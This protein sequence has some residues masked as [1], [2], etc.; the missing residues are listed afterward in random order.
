MLFN[1]STVTPIKRVFPFDSGGF[2]EQLYAD[3]FHRDMHLEDFGLE[4]DPNTPGRVVSLFFRTP[5]SYL[6]AKPTDSIS[7]DPAE[8]EARS[9][10]ALINQ[11]LSNNM[12]NRVSGVEIQF[13]EPLPI[14]DGL[15]AIIL[16][17]TLYSSPSIAAKL[18]ALK[19]EALPY[20]QID[21]QRPSEYVTKLF[22]LC[23]DYYRK[24]GLI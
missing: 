23:T 19:V 6:K 24:R 16:P 10:L 20:D 8:L 15:E 5:E 12:D 4:P 18:S 17:D 21:R 3:A 13:E 22:D 7:L 9:Y 1:T 2:N 14:A 11:R